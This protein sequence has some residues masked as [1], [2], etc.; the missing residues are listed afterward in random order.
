MGEV[1]V[2]GKWLLGEAPEEWVRWMLADPTLEV[3]E[4]LT[5]EFRHVLRH[6]DALLRVRDVQGPFLLLVELQLHYDPKMPWRMQAYAA[7]AEEKYGLLVYP[8]VFYLL[9]PSSSVS[10][11]DRYYSEFRGLVAR[12]DFRVVKAWELEAREVVERGPLALVPLTPLMRGADED[13]VRAGAQVLR[14]QGAGE[15]MEVALALFASFRMDAEQIQQIVRWEMAVL[16]ESPWYQEIVQEGRQEGRQE[17]LLEAVL[18]LLRTRFDLSGSDVE[19]LATQ[20]QRVKEAEVLRQLLVNA[21]SAESID[22]FRASLEMAAVT[23]TL[24]PSVSV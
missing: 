9:P 1:D 5:A 13:V 3:E 7:L 10:L 6:S 14:E 4:F 15:E 20:L 18:H 19:G 21:A 16:R 8:L 12:R 23:M 17:G 11:P 2:S 22:E 24:A